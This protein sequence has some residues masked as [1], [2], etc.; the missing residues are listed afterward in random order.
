MRPLAL[1]TPSELM[2]SGNSFGCWKCSSPETTSSM[3]DYIVARV[4]QLQEATNV[5][6]RESL[7]Q[8]AK[9]QAM[10]RNSKR[11]S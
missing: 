7:S 4:K 5:N 6:E 2:G 3:C 9:T 11:A 8:I 1:H 10:H